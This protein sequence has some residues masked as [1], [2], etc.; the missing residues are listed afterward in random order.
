MFLDLLEI[1]GTKKTTQ[2]IYDFLLKSIKKW[3]LNIQ[4]RVGFGYDRAT[5]IS[6]QP[7]VPCSMTT[8]LKKISPFVISTY[9]ITHKI[10]LIALEATKSIECKS[11]FIYLN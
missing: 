10:N 11:L 1:F 2:I 5:I 4:K 6:G 7:Q 8:K 3:G 9:F